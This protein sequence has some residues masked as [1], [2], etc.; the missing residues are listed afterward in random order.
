MRT[1]PFSPIYQRL[2]TGA[3]KT[4]SPDMPIIID[5]EITN[6]CNFNCLFCYTGTKAHKRPIGFMPRELYKKIIDEIVFYT[7]PPPLRFSRWGEPTLHKNFMEYLRIAKMSGLMCHLNTNGSLLD[8]NTITE[9]LELKLDS[10]KFSFQG[11]DEKTYGEMRYMQSFGKLADTVKRFSELRGGLAYPYMHAA[12]T[13]TY[14]TEE[15]IQSFKDLLTPY[16]DLVTVGHTK[17]SHISSEQTKV[18]AEAKK[19]L[20]NLK[21]A[22]S[23]EKTYKICNE[24]YD[25]LS[26]NW[27]GTV[28]ACCGD[29]DNLMIVGDL[30]KTSLRDIYKNSEELRNYRA[31]L[32]AYRH[33]E[34]PLCRNC[35]DTMG[36]MK[37]V[38]KA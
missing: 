12:T 7:T 9:L 25:K 15:M 1:N 16:C 31:M 37:A 20:D 34:L 38:A 6:A 33:A 14:E 4:T 29:Y 10:I 22:E 11:T 3:A 18:P 2:N 19:L 30:N 28:S 36:L 24:A 21:S 17:L 23:I 35:Y 5:I 8:E 13:V 27:D 26:I 32:A